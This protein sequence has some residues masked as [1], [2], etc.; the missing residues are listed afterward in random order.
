MQPDCGAVQ[1]WWA[2]LLNVWK[3]AG[4]G[5]VFAAVLLAFGIDTT[6]KGWAARSWNN[7]FSSPELAG[8]VRLDRNELL[9]S[10]ANPGGE[11]AS[12][13]FVGLTVNSEFGPFRWTNRSVAWTLPEGFKGQGPIPGSGETLE[14]IAHPI[15]PATGEEEEETFFTTFEERC[16]Y[17]VTFEFDG[18][19][20]SVPAA[21]KSCECGSACAL[22]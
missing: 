11:D 22:P 2:H 21:G 7:L 16:T 18:K 20:Q 5:A 8:E 14:L 10:V 12:L 19:R 17:T 13:K 4:L 15:N 1:Y 9:L 6:E 3:L